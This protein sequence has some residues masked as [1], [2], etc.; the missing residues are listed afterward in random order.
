MHD[1]FHDQLE[2]CEAAH[3]ALMSYQQNVCMPQSTHLL[4]RM[5]VGAAPGPWLR[6]ELDWN[7]E[8]LSDVYQNLCTEFEKVLEQEIATVRPPVFPAVPPV[9]RGTQAEENAQLRA[10]RLWERFD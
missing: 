10:A 6:G 4:N 8:I 3:H 2:R 9:A 5:P 7:I 1:L